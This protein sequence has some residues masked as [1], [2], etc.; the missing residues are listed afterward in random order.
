MH[1]YYPAIL[2]V[3]W[4]PW[5]PQLLTCLAQREGQYIL[6]LLC[7]VGKAF[8]PAMYFPIRTLYLTLK[9]EQKE[10]GTCRSVF[11]ERE[12]LGEGKRE[13]ER[14]REIIYVAQYFDSKISIL[15][16]C[17]FNISLFCTC[18]LSVKADQ[19][20]KASTSQAPSATSGGES[21]DITTPG[22][23]AKVLVS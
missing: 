6:N 13:R 15:S 8:P 17:M 4:L 22:D 5:I 21:M 14:E 11:R 10:K 1:K 2:P 20:S 23:V 9:M 12:R 16:P 18:I 7:Y 3:N 19:Q